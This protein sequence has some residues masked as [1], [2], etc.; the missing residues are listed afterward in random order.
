MIGIGLS[1]MIIVFDLG[2][3]FT[4]WLILLVPAS[5]LG[6]LIDQ[7]FT[8]LAYAVTFIYLIDSGTNYLKFKTELLLPYGSLILLVGG[9]HLIEGILTSLYGYKENKCI[10]TYKGNKIA[11]GYQAYRKWRIPLFLFVLNGIYVPIIVVM[12]YGDDTYTMNPKKK[13]QKMGLYIGIYGLIMIFLSFIS[14][15]SRLLPITILCMPILHE[16]MLKISKKQEEKEPLYSYPNRGVRVIEILNQEEGK[17]FL[18]RGDI[19]LS[20]NN[21]EINELE[22]YDKIINEEALVIKIETLQG[23]EKIVCCKGK[24]LHQLGVILLPRM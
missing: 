21:Q 4:W 7:H 24:E 5:I 13:A 19:I 1:T 20:I 22:A 2:I 8:C 3:P 9:L 6:G 11:G 15:E 14:H 17:S 18:K 23:G 16:L 12:V 10:I